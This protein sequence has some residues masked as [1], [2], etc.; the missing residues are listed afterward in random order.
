MNGLTEELF[1]LN[2]TQR[3]KLS[4]FEMKHAVNI[5]GLYVTAAMMYPVPQVAIKI[6]LLSGPHV[7]GS[8]KAIYWYSYKLHH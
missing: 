1:W 2:L 4:V 3:C 5:L 7:L 8:S 6:A